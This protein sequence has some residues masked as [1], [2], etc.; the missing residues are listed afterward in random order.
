MKTTVILLLISLSV[1]F[2]TAYGQ[3][4]KKC[5]EPVASFEGILL[6][7][8][9][10]RGTI[11]IGEVEITAVSG[12]KITFKITQ[13]TTEIIINDQ[14]K[15]QFVKGKRI[16]FT[17][18]NY[19][20]EQ[21]A[22]ETWSNGNKK[23]EGNTLCG[24]KIGPWKYYNLY[25][26]L[27][28]SYALNNKGE[29]DG[30][31]QE[32]HPNGQVAM[33]VLY[34]NG[35]KQENPIYYYSN[36]NKKMVVSI[37]AFGHIHGTYTKWYKDGNLM[38]EGTLDDGKLTGAFVSYHPNGKI[39]EQG[40]YSHHHKKTDEWKA[41][42]PNGKRKYQ[43][44]YNYSGQLIGE[45]T[46]FFENGKVA[47]KTRYDAFGDK[48]GK[49]IEYHASRRVKE[50]INYRNNKR[51]GEWVRYN[52]KGWL[53][54]KGNYR[55]DHL[56]GAYV[57]YTDEAVKIK[58]GRY[59]KGKKTGKWT[60]YYLNSKM[61]KVVHYDH[62]EIEGVYISYYNSG[63]LEEK[64]YKVND[65]FTGEYEHYYS[66]GHLIEKGTYTYNGEKTGLWVTFYENGKPKSK[67]SYNNGKKVGK[68]LD[69]NEQG[70]K[71]K[72]QF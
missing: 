29:R 34:E 40:T 13:I 48:D 60:Y 16:S 51:E 8:K 9:V 10:M 6:L 18:Y 14:S 43:V 59:Y 55:D 15:N 38:E 25:G 23:A 57:K 62:D 45:N 21:L 47:K 52:D 53:L 7:G 12:N 35:R 2:P 67:G 41:F 11:G 20:Q 36:G 30:L 72:T 68:W 42:Y 33:K 4:L 3:T 63:Q 56:S 1:C 26:V 44:N 54:E 39:H 22:V 49:W 70:K 17:Q 24:K 65:I 5:S 50:A 32:Y 61:Q 37:N 58:E 66:N 46:F 69:W 71:V 19:E 64:G 31:Y 28:K 27:E